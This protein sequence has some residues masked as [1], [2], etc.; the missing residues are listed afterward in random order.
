M[1]KVIYYSHREGKGRQRL[2]GC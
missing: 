2:T 1:N